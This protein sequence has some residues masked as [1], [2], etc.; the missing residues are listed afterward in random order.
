M[1]HEEY[2]WQLGDDFINLFNSHHEQTFTPGITVCVN[3]SMVHWHGN[4]RDWIHA[5]L[6]SHIAIKRKSENG[7]EVHSSC[8]RGSGI[9]MQ[10]KIRKTKACTLHELLWQEGPSINKGARVLKEL[11]VPWANTKRLVVADSAFSSVQTANEL[12]RI[13]LHKALL[14]EAFE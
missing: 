12:H 1:L 9:M 3:E 6:L 5:G 11:V 7:A 14:L 2:Y 13:G 8:C 10:L 4:D